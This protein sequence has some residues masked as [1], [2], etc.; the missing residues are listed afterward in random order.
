MKA[1]DKEKMKN[2]YMPRRINF[3]RKSSLYT[4][5][6]NV[7]DEESVSEGCSSDGEREFNLFMAQE[8]LFF[9]DEEEEIEVVVDLEGELVSALEELRKV[10]KEYKKYKNAVTQEQDLLN[11]SL[12]KSKRTISNLKIQLEEEKRMYEVTKLYLE[13]KDKESQN[14]KQDLVD[15]RKELENKKDELTMR[16]KYD[17]STEALDKMLSKQNHNK[18]IN[19]V[20]FD[21]GQ[22][23][24]SK[25]SSGN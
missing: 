6:D 20:G 22:C 3:R 5:Q 13:N 16:I 18:D 24:N 15:L 2:S 17:G 7:S 25:D 14:L 1:L 4:F 23:S 9:D 19:G 8:G 12:E 11:K 21:K 10:R